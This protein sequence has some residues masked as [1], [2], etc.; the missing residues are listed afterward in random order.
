MKLIFFSNIPDTIFRVFFRN[1][2]VFRCLCYFYE[3]QNLM[4]YISSIPEN[5]IRKIKTN[6]EAPIG[7]THT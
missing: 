5:E 7:S 4:R 3:K 1:M 6:L 2:N